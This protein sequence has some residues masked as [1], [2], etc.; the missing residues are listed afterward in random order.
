MLFKV[1]ARFSRA[2]VITVHLSQKERPLVN[3]YPST[4]RWAHGYSQG[5]RMLRRQRHQH[6]RYRSTLD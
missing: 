1:G 6:W 4:Q 5:M 2:R 3:L